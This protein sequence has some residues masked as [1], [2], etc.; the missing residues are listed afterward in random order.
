ML[1]AH[2]N[3][4]ACARALDEERFVNQVRSRNC[5]G[6]KLDRTTTSRTKNDVRRR[7]LPFM[8]GAKNGAETTH[9]RGILFDV[10]RAETA[11]S[12]VRLGRE[13]GRR[14]FRHRR[15]CLWFA[16]R[17]RSLSHYI[18]RRGS[19]FS[20][21]LRHRILRRGRFGRVSP[22]S[23]GF[24]CLVF[25]AFFLLGRE[26][27]NRCHDGLFFV[28]AFLIFLLPDAARHELARRALRG[29]GFARTG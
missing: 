18:C 5:T 14:R 1:V 10:H 7:W 4:F 28:N 2:V 26:I 6:E 19:S 16:R 8:S 23:L 3:D 20:R 17:F 25:N 29:I 13:R 9:E 27:L 12:D 11:Q 15:L 21:R 22:S 24:G